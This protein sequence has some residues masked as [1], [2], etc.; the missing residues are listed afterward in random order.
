VEDPSDD[1]EVLRDYVDSRD[2]QSLKTYAPENLKKR[3]SPEMAAEANRV[4]K[5]T[6][7]I[8]FN[9]RYGQSV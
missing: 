1:F 6:K 7:V 8:Q 4:L 9:L 3:F 2:C 5:M